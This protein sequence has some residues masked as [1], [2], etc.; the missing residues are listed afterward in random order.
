MVDLIVEDGT[1]QADANSYVTIAAARKYAA[2]RNITLSADDNE[3]AGML[4]AACDFIETQGPFQGTEKVQTQRLSFPRAG[5]FFRNQHYVDALV[6][7]QIREA[8][9]QLVLDI[10]ENG[11]LMTSKSEYAVKKRVLEG[12]ATEYAV[13]PYAEAKR[14]AINPLARKLIRMFILPGRSSARVVR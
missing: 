5:M 6:P 7:T 8:Q 12:L 14:R 13:G 11:P 10:K 2:D 1:G 9:L 4:V 3:V